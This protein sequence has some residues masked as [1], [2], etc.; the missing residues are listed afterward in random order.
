VNQYTPD[1][2]YTAKYATKGDQSTAGQAFVAK[3]LNLKVAKFDD[4]KTD[5][6]KSVIIEAAKH[7]E[8]E[9][10]VGAQ[11]VFRDLISVHIGQHYV[12]PDEHEVHLK[13]GGFAGY[14]HSGS[15]KYDAAAVGVDPVSRKTRCLYNDGYLKRLNSRKIALGLPDSAT[16][17]EILAENVLL[18]MMP[19]YVSPVGT[20][21]LTTGR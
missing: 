14:K 19:F 9:Q 5:P 17:E 20:T 4:V 7:L 1:S 11:Q 13:I 2:N 16:A 18:L 15:L 10:S 3:K 8:A 21:L 6:A 12:L